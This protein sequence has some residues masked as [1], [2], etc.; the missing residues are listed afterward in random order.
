MSRA[1]TGR[2]VMGQKQAESDAAAVLS[3]F[4]RR[5]A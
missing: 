1:M 5:S 2:T 3:R 4:P